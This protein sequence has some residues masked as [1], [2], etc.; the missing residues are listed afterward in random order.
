[1]NILT[2]T[3]RELKSYFLSPI[4]YVIT[5][6]FALFTGANFFTQLLSSSQADLSGDFG[7][8]MVL[9]LFLAPALTMR[10]F[11]EENRA[12]TIELLMTAPVRDW[13][14]VVG[15]YLAGLLGF[16]ALLIPT[17]WHVVIVARYGSPD[18]GPIAAGY[19]ALL[20]V[21]I[22]FVAVGLLTSSVT[23][24][25]VIA[26]ILGTIVLLLL[27]FSGFFAQAAQ[28][29]Q[30]LSDA[31]NFLY[32]PGHFQDFFNG[33]IDS[34]HV[35]YFFSLAAIAIFLTVRVVESRRWR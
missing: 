2:I 17:L 25:Q 26:Y 12:G 33:V 4:A 15:K 3:G 30:V 1:M 9:A 19:V 16:I 20:L 27:W 34:T 29:A 11:A 7:L 13:E 23:Q 18:Y 14:I 10:L 32:L 22:S 8:M 31:L 21:G 24:N 35:L 6:V 28:S 5:G